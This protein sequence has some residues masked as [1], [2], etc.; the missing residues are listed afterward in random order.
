MNYRN[1]FKLIFS[2]IIAHSAG[3]IGSLFTVSAIATWYEGLVKPVFNPPNWIFGPVWLVLYTLMG[4]ALYLIWNKG[5]SNKQVRFTF[6][7]FIVHLIFNALWSIVFFGLQNILLGLIVI[8][9]LWLMILSLISL[10][11]KIDRRAS[12]LLMPYLL[13]VSF[14]TLLNFS[15]LQLNL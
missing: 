1:I 13:W 15:I 6:I 14:A 4:V 12:Y 3:I 2:I 11:W 9:V 7:F 10:S 5:L 8:L